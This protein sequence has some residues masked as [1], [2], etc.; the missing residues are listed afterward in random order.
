MKPSRNYEE[1]EALL[2]RLE[3]LHKSFRAS[4]GP[5]NKSRKWAVWQLQGALLCLGY[6]GLA[7]QKTYQ[8]VVIL[9][10]NVRLSSEF[11]NQVNYF[12]NP[13]TTSKAI[14]KWWKA[15]NPFLYPTKI[16]ELSYTG[17]KKRE[18][19]HAKQKTLPIGVDFS[20]G[21]YNKGFNNDLSLWMHPSFNLTH[22]LFA[23]DTNRGLYKQYELKLAIRHE[24]WINLAT[25]EL[26][27]NV[28]K[29]LHLGSYLFGEAINLSSLG[30]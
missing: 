4:L 11:L 14:Q 7:Y 5:Q 13:N 8:D 19:V 12:A 1:N 30:L 22:H 29:A 9:M 27:N 20:I 6:R 23:T 15:Y 10:M 18:D 28:G 3:A 17:F 21:M 24:D 16:E 26:V 25:S 2:A